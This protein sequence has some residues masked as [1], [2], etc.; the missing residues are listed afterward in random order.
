MMVFI[1]WCVPDMVILAQGFW[2][3]VTYQT[4]TFLPGNVISQKSEKDVGIMV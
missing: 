2:R 1:T 4:V 3:I